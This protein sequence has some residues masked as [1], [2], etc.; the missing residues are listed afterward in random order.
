MPMMGNDWLARAAGVAR[1]AVFAG[2]FGWG[3]GADFICMSMPDWPGGLKLLVAQVSNLLYRR[4][5]V[6]K[7]LRLPAR[8]RVSRLAGWKP[9]I[10]QTGSLRY[11]ELDAAPRLLM[12]HGS[13]W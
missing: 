13:A 4:L 9:A 8:E 7:A 5:P 1:R 12:W 6:G 2:F 10:Q 3:F 11:G